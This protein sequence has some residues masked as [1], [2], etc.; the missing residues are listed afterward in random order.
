[1]R[2]VGTDENLKPLTGKISRVTITSPSSVRTMQW[3]NLDLGVGKYTY[4]E[5]VNVIIINGYLFL[6]YERKMIN[7]SQFN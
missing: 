7:N 1:M 3:D 2:I 6:G 4:R 5:C